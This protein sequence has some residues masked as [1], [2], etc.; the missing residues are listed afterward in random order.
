MKV[1]DNKLFSIEPQQGKLEPGECRT[2]SF[3]YRH[4]MAGTD[5]LP[6]LLKLARGREILV[7]L[8]SVLK[9]KFQLHISFSKK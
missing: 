8:S 9:K 2:V 6:V 4:T 7:R 1:M 3:T 5:R